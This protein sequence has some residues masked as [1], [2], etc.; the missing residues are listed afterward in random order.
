MKT[1]KKIGLRFEV[2]IELFKFLWQRKL[3]WLFPLAFLVVLL[4]LIIAFGTASGI[5]PFI[6]TVF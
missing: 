5:G 6:Y 1:I 3:W 4:G 2:A